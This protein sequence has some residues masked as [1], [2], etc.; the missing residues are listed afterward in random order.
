MSLE[1]GGPGSPNSSTMRS[2]CR[3]QLQS[4]AR[5]LFSQL[6]LLEGSHCKLVACCE[7]C[8]VQPAPA[9]ESCRQ[10]DGNVWSL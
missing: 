1:A 6:E 2:T 8:H 5:W 9:T 10:Q 4:A 7:L 3:R